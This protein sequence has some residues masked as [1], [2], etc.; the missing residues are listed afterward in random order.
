MVGTSQHELAVP[1]VGFAAGMMLQSVLYTWLH[2]NTGS[3]LWTAIFF[4]WVST[5][6]MQ[7]VSSGATRSALYDGLENVPLLILAAAVVLWWGPR[8]LRG[9]PGSAAAQVQ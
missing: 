5:Y 7:V 9:N 1:F 3:S 2:N 8:T 4:H 6:A